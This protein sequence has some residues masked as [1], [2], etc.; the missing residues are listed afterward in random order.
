V[1]P[2]GRFD[3]LDGDSDVISA[4]PDAAWTT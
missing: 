1:S 3:Q 2:G 4:V